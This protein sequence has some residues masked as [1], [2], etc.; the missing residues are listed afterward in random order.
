MTQILSRIKET[1]DS[2]PRKTAYKVNGESVTYGG[3]WLNAEKQARLLEKQGNSPVI[4]FGHKEPFVIESIVACLIAGRAYVPVDVSTPFKRVEQ[5]AA[6][7]GSTLILTRE[8]IRIENCD[9]L[10][11]EDLKRY[12]QNAVFAQK[13]DIAYIIFTSGSTGEPKGVPVFN[14]SLCNFVDWIS[15]LHP[16]CEYKNINVLNT[17]NFSFDLSVADLFYALCNGHTLIAADKS[18]REEPVKLFSLLKE[19]NVAVMTPTFAK[20]CLLDSDFNGSVFPGLKC[21]YFCGEAL[22]PKTAKKLLAAFPGIKI[23]NAYGPTEATCSVSAAPITE[24]EADG[25]DILPVGVKNHFAAGI[26]IEDG[27]IVLKGRSV[28]GG[29]LNGVPGGHF[30]EGGVNCYRTG[31]LG[32]FEGD[33]LFCRGRKDSQIKYKGYRI[34]LGDIEN[35]IKKI[36]GVTDCAVIAKRGGENAVRTIKAF[37]SGDGIDSDTI[38]TE[39]KKRL[40]EY[41]I[42]KTVVITDLPVNENGKIDRKALSEL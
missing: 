23:L 32:G 11:P 31:D 24:K 18:A 29:Y 26:E 7:T 28:F 25:M 13:G 39:L 41:M 42:P 38:K 30:T 3:L 40:P 1:A 14:D 33:F 2:A 9:S 22:E 17:A 15:G 6:A 19:I 21:I 36:D 10:R 27:E 8:E 20:F 4:I 5:I 16:L 12:E 37:V 34:E 35:N